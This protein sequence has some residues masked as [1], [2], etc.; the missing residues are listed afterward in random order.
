M[1]EVADVS[2]QDVTLSIFMPI[3]NREIDTRKGLAQQRAE[4][5]TLFAKAGG[6]DQ[7]HWGPSLEGARFQRA[8][9]TARRAT[10]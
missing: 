10:P 5:Y 7:G 6:K 9:L 8:R 4:V 2:T 1:A 3:S